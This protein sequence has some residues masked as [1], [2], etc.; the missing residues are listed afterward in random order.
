MPIKSYRGI[1]DRFQSE[2]K[3]YLAVLVI[4]IIAELIGTKEFSIGPGAM[5]FFPMFYGLILGVLLVPQITGF[6]KIKEVKAASTL[7]LVAITPFMAKLGVMAGGNLPKL[8][9]V[10]PALVLQEFGNLGTILIALPLAILLGLKREAIGATHSICRESNLGL[11]T[12]VYGPDSPETRGTLSIYVIGYIIGVIYFGFLASAAAS[13]K[14]FHPLALAMAS[15]AGSG[16]MMAASTGVLANIYPDMA[17]DILVLGAA[18]D[19][20]TGVT[21]LYVGLFIALPLATKLYEFLEPR[22]RKISLKSASTVPNA[23]EES[24]HENA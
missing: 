7:V 6:F 24:K 22:M 14:I 21:G 8:V 18:S 20:L 10:G 9:E 12:H 2:Y 17:E 16:S 15:G 5:I 3:I 19:M 13:M 11:V 4:V 1:G 23:E